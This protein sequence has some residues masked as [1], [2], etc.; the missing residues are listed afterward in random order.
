MEDMIEILENLQK[1]FPKDSN[2]EPVVTFLAGDQLT[3]ERIRGAKRAR[4]Q[5]E[6]PLEQFQGIL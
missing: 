1:Y 6:D 3:C 2:G 4:V 5:P